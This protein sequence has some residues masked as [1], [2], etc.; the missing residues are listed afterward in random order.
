MRIEYRDLRHGVVRVRLESLDDMWYLSRVVV[1]GDIVKGRTH[2]RIK[3]KD[4]TRSSGGER[5][6]ITLAVKVESAEFKSDSKAL[7]VSGVIVDSSDEAVAAGGHHTFNLE[8]GESVTVVKDRWG[9][10]DLDLVDEAVKGTLRPKVIVVSVDEGE[11]VA[12]LVRESR[13]EYYELNRN[14]GGK[15]D[16]KGRDARKTEFYAE[17]AALVDGIAGRENVSHM[18]LSG[19]GFEKNGFHRYLVDA[20]HRLTAGCVIQ[21]TGQSGR[22]GVQ[23]VLKRGALSRTLEEVSAV[24]DVR[25]VEDLLADI[26]RDT[27]LSV[28]GAAEVAAA[29]DAGAVELLLVTDVALAKDRARVERRIS[30]TRAGGGRVHIVNSEGEAGQKLASLGGVAAK[31]R[32]RMR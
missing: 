27:G 32:Y 29:A 15:Y 8:G 23:E 6:T 9:K 22:A 1:P 16:V 31:L 11:A 4:D 18:V 24:R 7:R 12:G 2:R 25:F 10:T 21:D 13:V 28:Y 26:G 17:L 20:R 5:K 3:D 19:P 14:I 30:S